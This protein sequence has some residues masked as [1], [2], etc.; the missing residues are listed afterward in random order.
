[1]KNAYVDW[2]CENGDKL[3]MGLIGTNSYGVQEKTWGYR[4]VEKSVLDKYKMTNTA[5]FGIGYSH[6]IGNYS[7]SAQLLT[8][9]S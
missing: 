1:M 4:F 8:E 3:S 2:K 7:L 9:N 5:D 6:K